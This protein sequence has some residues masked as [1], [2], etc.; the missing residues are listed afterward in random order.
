[1]S[2]PPST[3]QPVNTPVYLPDEILILIA[4]VVDAEDLSTLRAVSKLFHHETETRF[5]DTYFTN[6]YYPAT[7]QGLARLIGITK[8]P[9]FSQK[10]AASS[11]S[12]MLSHLKEDGRQLSGVHLDSGKHT[13]RLLS[14]CRH[15]T[16]ASC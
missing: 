10:S 6:V 16:L 8:H 9:L 11:A 1:M 14:L 2:D 13:M 7:P 12:A 3:L 4:R 5:A 15:A